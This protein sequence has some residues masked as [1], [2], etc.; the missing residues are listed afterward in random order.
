MIPP[1]TPSSASFRN[2]L[3]E[4]ICSSRSRA[5]AGVDVDVYR[6]GNVEFL[7]PHPE[8]LVSIQVTSCPRLYQ[9]RNGLMLERPL[10]A[11]EVIVTPAGEPKAWRREGLGVL[12]LMG[13]APQFLDELM[14]QA[15]GHAA[16]VE[17]L[18]N[19]GTRD[20]QIEALGDS[21][22]NE[23]RG[24]RLGS[25]MYAHA[26]CM[27]LGLHLL[28][29][30]AN[31]SLRDEGPLPMPAHKLRTARNFIEE[32]LAEDL[33]IE[34]IAR[35]VGM[36]PYHFAHAFKAAAGLPPHKFVMQRRLEVAKSLLRGSSLGLTEI[37]QRVGYSSASH[38]S[39]G[40]HKLARVSPSEFRKGSRGEKSKFADAVHKD[41]N[42]ALEPRG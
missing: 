24:E 9:R 14:E 11:G 2:Y 3:P 32:N 25:R 31:V 37:A 13:I 5:W 23:L 35:A 1:A 12:L 17:L 33:N 38:F 34:A 20:P 16:H 10:P 39:S 7:A 30:Y 40:F 15:T 8:H 26:L 4:P 21:L 28:R 36:S 42:A 6:L 29:N 18:D 19:F 22:W 41:S 27:Q